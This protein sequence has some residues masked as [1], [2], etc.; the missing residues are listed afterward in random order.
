MVDTPAITSTIGGESAMEKNVNISQTIYFNLHTYT[1]NAVTRVI[2]PREKKLRNLKRNTVLPFSSAETVI[3]LS[4]HNLMAEHL[5]ILKLGLTLISSFSLP[6]AELMRSLDL[7]QEIIKVLLLS[8]LINRT[9]VRNLIFGKQKEKLVADLSDVAQSYVSS[10]EPV[11]DF[12]GTRK[13]QR[14]SYT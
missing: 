7:N 10:H 12:K 11:Q 1:K 9:K 8:K 5:G 14:H 13:E 3:N 4:S 6:S 2:N